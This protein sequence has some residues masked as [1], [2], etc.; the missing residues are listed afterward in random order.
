MFSDTT[1]QRK[2]G[3]DTDIDPDKN[4]CVIGVPMYH[5]NLYQVIRDNEKWLQESRSNSSRRG[6]FTSYT[7]QIRTPED[8]Q[9]IMK[10]I[11]DLREIKSELFIDFTFHKKPHYVSIANYVT[12]FIRIK[13]IYNYYTFLHWY[14]ITIH[15]ESGDEECKQDGKKRELIIIPLLIRIKKNKSYEQLK[16]INYI[17]TSGTEYEVKPI[18]TRY[19]LKDNPDDDKN[20]YDVDRSYGARTNPKY[21]VDYDKFEEE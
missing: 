18:N 14:R 19:F 9:K 16:S 11:K 5:D 21:V 20:S 8:L 15:P 2:P 13:G 4:N 17:N 12:E 10:I 7:K 3:F 1:V 6:K